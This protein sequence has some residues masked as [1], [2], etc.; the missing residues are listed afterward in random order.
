M[1]VG[2]GGR[3]GGVG[4]T[5]LPA[6]ARGPLAPGGCVRLPV[7]EL[8]SVGP[9]SELGGGGRVVALTSQGTHLE[10]P[11]PLPLSVPRASAENTSSSSSLIPAEADS[12]KR[13]FVER[14]FDSGAG[15][16]PEHLSSRSVRTRPPGR[17]LGPKEGSHTICRPNRDAFVWDRR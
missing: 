8:G 9:A 2:V 5:A 11:S 17:T 14:R 10:C 16:L 4:S 12:V 6:P 13:A 3:R 7:G 1:L 15:A